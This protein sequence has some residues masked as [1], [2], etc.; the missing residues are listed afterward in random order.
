MSDAI[1]RRRLLFGAGAALAAGALPGC[2]AIGDRRA[3][4]GAGGLGPAGAW[5]QP[6]RLSMDRVTGV[7][8]CSRPFRAAGP[9]L[10]L[11]KIGQQSVIHHYGHGGSG[12]SLSWGSGALAAQMA[13]AT[14]ERDIGVIGCGA[15]GLTTAVQLQRMGA[16]EVTIIARDLPPEVLSSFATGVWSPA[17]RIGLKPALTP[18]FRQR[19]QKM[20][21]HSW[22]V[23][24]NLLSL[25]GNPVEYVETYGLSDTPP[26]ERTRDPPADGRAPFAE[27]EKELV[28][29]IG[30]KA[31][32]VD[33]SATPFS[34]P[35]VQRSARL[36][37]NLPA[38]SRMLLGDFRAAGGR[39]R[40]DEFHTPA[41][42]ARLPQKT[43]V[44]CT[45]YGARA[46]MRDESVIPV[47]GQL[48]HVAPQMEAF[49]GVNY[50]KVGLTPRRDGFVLQY[51]GDGDYYGYDD[52]ST[53]P[54]MDVAELTIRTLAGAFA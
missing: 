12:W 34:A 33:A 36:M 38:Y 44:N 24:N 20:A 30:V 4:R 11:E 45:G 17:S 32:M 26:T 41:D 22:R 18:E 40:I 23:F 13:L 10:E 29:E 46:L 51:Q 1:A 49:Y 27:L 35:Y 43:L 14:G 25:P 42:F 47:R 8:V 9:R 16:R 21:R 2:T 3:L 50:R 28:P 39:I 19:W 15:I 54:D 52:A 31:A 6:M 7:T 5:L 53:V 48:T 37:F